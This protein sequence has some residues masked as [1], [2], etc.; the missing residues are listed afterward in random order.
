GTA[1]LVFSSANI[2]SGMT[3]GAYNPTLTLSDANHSYSQQI[4]TTAN[5]VSVLSA[6]PTTGTLTIVKTVVNDD[7][8]TLQA[9]DFSFFIDGSAV[10]SGSPQTVS[11]GI[12]RASETPAFGYSASVWSGDC[13]A[14]GD[15]NVVVGFSYSCAIS[16]DDIAPTLTLI[17]HVDNSLGGTLN[18]S[19]FN[20]FVDSSAALNGTPVNVTAGLHQVSEDSV[21][22]YVRSD[23]NGD[24][25]AQGNVVLSL[26]QNAVC[27][28]TN[29]FVPPAPTDGNLIVFKHVVND[30]GGTKLA[31]DFSINVDGNVN[32][33]FSGDE[34]GTLW[35]F[36]QGQYAISESPVSGYTLTHLIC[37]NAADSN[38]I[39]GNN[40]VDIVAGETRKCWLEN[41]DVSPSLT[42]VKV[43]NNNFGGTLSSNDFTLRILDGSTEIASGNG[44]VSASNLVAGTVYSISEDSVSDYVLD[45]SANCSINGDE[46]VFSNSI[47]LALEDNAVCTLSNND[48]APHLVVQKRIDNFHGGTATLDDFNIVLLDAQQNTVAVG[49]FGYLDVRMNAGAYSISETGPDGYLQEGAIS[50]SNGSVS[51]DLN[52]DN[53]LPLGIGDAF[54]C[55]I[56]NADIPPR[57]SISVS[58]TND[59]GGTAA[60][61]D[62]NVFIDSMQVVAG[63]PLD[64]NAG[65]FTVSA[66]SLSNY[67]ASDWSGDCSAS[68]AIDLNIGD[69][70]AC[71]ISFNDNA[72][73][74]SNPPGGGG[75]SGGGGGGSSGTTVTTVAKKN[76]APETTLSASVQNLTAVFSAQCSDS[77]GNISS[78]VLD[79]GDGTTKVLENIETVQT[80]SHLFASAGTFTASLGALD[81][82]NVSDPTPATLSVTISAPE[83]PT[84]T[85]EPYSA[86]PTGL[87]VAGANAWLFGL[88]LISI[89]FEAFAIQ[90]FRGSRAKP[91][92]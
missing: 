55:N 82:K 15:V 50:C 73:V 47:V 12:R 87:A 62:V 92:K 52:S 91:K 37:E 49:L 13:N 56:V 3:L 88:L 77:D 41:D 90:R 76:L 24:C 40:I 38:G 74:P 71:S 44:S 57:I 35:V 30:N 34:S 23:W 39:D 63:I 18:A 72:P 80:V 32:V 70:K 83:A 65:S 42:I 81:N 6:P 43:V 28:V 61:S 46:S 33:Q 9:S 84:P 26:G 11:P 31:S 75:G 67:T 20:L 69:S 59:N 29:T 54:D 53:S 5:S 51:F 89:S 14:D 79:F 4:A 68:G 45:G 78:C 36:P 10:S 86:P 22:G 48:I 17:K 27:E 85:P 66:T 25:D 1:T 8:G 2:P 21:P 60:A 19:D 58:I 64:W 7:G 16:N